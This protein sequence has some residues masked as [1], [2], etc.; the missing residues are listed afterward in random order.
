[1]TNFSALHRDPS[2]EDFEHQLRDAIPEHYGRFIDGEPMVF[3]ELVSDHMHL[4]VYCWA[5]TQ[6]RNMWTMV[7]AGMSAHQMNVQ[8]GHEHYQ[9]A[10]FVITLPGDWPDLNTIQR[11]PRSKAHRFFWPIEAMKSF[12]RIPYLHDTW[13]GIGH[14]TQAGRGIRDV[15]KGSDFT[16]LLV[17][18]ILSMPEEAMTLEVDDNLVH[19]H[20]L[21]P[22]YTEELQF[23]VN[24]PFSGKSHD[25]HHRF[26]GAGLYEGVFPDRSMLI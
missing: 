13:I 19:C 25:L 2:V 3:H 9:R 21:Y 6:Q 14:T 8:P 20:G 24:Q 17:A 22:L 1:M 23:I 4:D 5:P 18:P 7:T 10:E 15:Y 12:A 11:M 16:G 26:M